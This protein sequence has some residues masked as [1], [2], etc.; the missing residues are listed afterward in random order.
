MSLQEEISKA[1]GAHGMWKQRLKQAIDGGSSEFTVER[2]KADNNCDFGKWLYSLGD[3][4]KGT[5]NFK[6]V[7]ELHADFH[8]VASDVLGKALKG[9]KTAATAAMDGA[10]A[11]ASSKL[12]AAMMAWKK[13]AP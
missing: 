2:V 5:A 3:K 6:S 13:D 1:I 9:D 10:F 11:S 8:K 7:R 4:E 12:T